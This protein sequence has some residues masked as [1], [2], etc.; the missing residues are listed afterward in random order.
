MIVIAPY[1]ASYSYYAGLLLVF[2]YGYS[3]LK[4][5]FVWASATMWVVVI[6]YEVAAIW[7]SSTPVATLINN[8]FFFY[9]ATSWGCS[10]AIR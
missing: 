5:R 7:L 6:A 1:P 3:F 10:H 8:N 9:P 2:I 4:L